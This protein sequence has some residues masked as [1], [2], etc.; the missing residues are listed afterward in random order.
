[1]G[2]ESACQ[3]R[4]HNRPEFN[5]G[6]RTFPVEGNGNPGKS[7]ILAWEIPWTKEPDGLQ[8]LGSKRVGHDY[9]CTHT[10]FQQCCPNHLEKGEEKKSRRMKTTD[11]ITSSNLKCSFDF[12]LTSLS[13]SSSLYHCQLSWSQHSTLTKQLL[14]HCPKDLTLNPHNNPRK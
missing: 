12:Q 1:M 9:A 2:K 3:R 14:W 4:R 6:S 8:S 7:S 5:P 11:L 13:G 10:G